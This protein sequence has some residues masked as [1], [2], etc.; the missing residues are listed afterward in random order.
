MRVQVQETNLE[1]EQMTE[2][3]SRSKGKK[4][5]QQKAD[6]VSKVGLTEEDLNRWAEARGV[7]TQRT[8]AAAGS[9][10]TR[11]LDPLPPRTPQ[12][13]EQRGD[14]PPARSCFKCRQEGHLAF[15]CPSL[16]SLVCYNCLQKGHQARYC[17]FEPWCTHCQRGGHNYRGCQARL[18]QATSGGQGNS[19]GASRSGTAA[20]PPPVRQ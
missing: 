19:E 17:Q 14:R 5:R 1:R 10:T 7:V 9:S 3:S 16:T 12:Q 18:R 15:E 6:E 11:S 8:L 4:G 13:P 2:A 20:A